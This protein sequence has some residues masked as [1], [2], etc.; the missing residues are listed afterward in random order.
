MCLSFAQA[1]GIQEIVCVICMTF[2]WFCERFCDRARLDPG[3]EIAALAEPQMRNAVIAKRRTNGIRINAKRNRS[4]RRH[5]RRGN[6]AASAA[7]R[8]VGCAG[9]SQR[10]GTRDQLWQCRLHPERD[11]PPPW[12]CRAISPPC[13]G[14]PAGRTNDVRYQPAARCRIIS[15]PAAILA[16]LGAGA[17][18][19]GA[20]AAYAPIIQRAGGRARHLHP[21]CRMPEISCSGMA[22]I[23][24]TVILPRSRPRSQSPR[25][26]R[27]DLWRA[28]SA[29]SAPRN[30][31]V[32][33]RA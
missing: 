11:G 6:G 3:I 30:C 10:A 14:S 33:N 26:V 2:E 8:L 4:R 15:A 16:E 23:C 25:A 28:S 12:R 5:G 24:S 13:S 21:R 1:K 9:R 22:T 29:F 27:A 31:L 17:V 20:T 32:P 19:R 7:S 18:M